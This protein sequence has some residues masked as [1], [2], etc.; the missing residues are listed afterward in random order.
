[1][2][3]IFWLLFKGGYRVMVVVWVYLMAH[4]MPFVVKLAYA[5]VQYDELDRRI[6]AIGKPIWEFFAHL[7]APIITWVLSAVAYVLT[8][9]TVSLDKR[10]IQNL[11]L[12]STPRDAAKYI[13][14]LTSMTL[15]AILL[16]LVPWLARR[17][18]I[19]WPE[20]RRDFHIPR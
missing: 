6:V 8:L 20:P 19:G 12:N 1:M 5:S 13:D 16:V 9:G 3:M 15:L 4:L 17:L 18:F 14:A 10:L 11:V 2:G 7:L